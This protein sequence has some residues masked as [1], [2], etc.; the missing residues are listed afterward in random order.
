MSRSVKTK[1]L[2]RNKSM[3]PLNTII[4]PAVVSDLPVLL[5][6]VRD[7]I[8]VMESQGIHQWDNIYPDEKTLQNDI[9]TNTLWIARIDGR[10]GGMIVLN[11]YQEPEYQQAQWRYEGRIL[12]VH[13]LMV[14]PAFQNQKLATHLMRFAEDYAA[15]KG[16][17]AIRLDAFMQNPY[18]VKLYRKLEYL[19]V[20]TVTFRKGVF[21]CFEK[22]ISLRW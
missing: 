20:G 1:R 7:C 8:A 10:I 2:L 15:D 6:V 22:K 13:R 16:Y 12:V 3:N 11:E 14:A 9:D 21:Y 19:E 4:N 5:E 18:A 17:D